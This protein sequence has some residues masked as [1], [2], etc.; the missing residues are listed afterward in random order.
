MKG[1][2]EMIRFRNLTDG[3]PDHWERGA[4]WFV[5]FHD[6]RMGFG[7]PL[8]IAFVTAFPCQVNLDHVFVFDECR[9]QRI[10]TRLIQACL[11]RWPS[12]LLKRPIDSVSEAFVAHLRRLSTHIPSQ[13]RAACGEGRRSECF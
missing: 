5:E 2:C 9:R 12:I 13:A 8:G 3:I 1:R 10:G 11:N 7:Y 6:D 4:H